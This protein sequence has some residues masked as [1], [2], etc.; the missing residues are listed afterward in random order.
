MLF[1]LAAFLA[2]LTFTLGAP[3]VQ[4]ISTTTTA[5]RVLP[6]TTPAPS[7]NCISDNFVSPWVINN[8]VIVSPPPGSNAYP[9]FI[10][11]N[12]YDPN[13]D[14]VL[15]TYCG[16]AVNKEGDVVLENGGYVACDDDSVRFQLQDEESILI[17]RWYKDPW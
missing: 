9:T 3:Q 15:N 2:L 10:S 12:F 6:S 1:L 17:S 8:L 5:S 13:E 14:L 7:P 11:F 4:S 16:G